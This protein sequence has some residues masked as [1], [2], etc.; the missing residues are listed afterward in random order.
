[1]RSDTVEKSQIRSKR[2]RYGRMRNNLVWFKCSCIKLNECVQLRWCWMNPL[3]FLLLYI[4]EYGCYL[5]LCKKE[6]KKWMARFFHLG[7]CAHVV[8]MLTSTWSLKWKFW[9]E[10]VKIRNKKI[11]TWWYT[12][13]CTYVCTMFLISHNE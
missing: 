11:Y 6:I 3:L 13:K 5:C 4:C 2:V 9:W 8:H 7:K 10:F 1:M 12:E